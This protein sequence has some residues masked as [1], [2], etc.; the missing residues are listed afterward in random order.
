MLLTAAHVV[1]SLSAAHGIE[2]GEVRL[3]TGPATGSAD[4]RIGDVAFSS[5]PEPEYEIELDASLVRLDSHVSLDNHVRETVTTKRPRMLD[6]GEDYVRVF[7]R[8]IN[9]PGLTEGLD[10]FF[11][12]WRIPHTSPQSSSP[13]AR[14][15]GQ[16]TTSTSLQSRFTKPH[17]QTDSLPPSPPPDLLVSDE[18]LADSSVPSGTLGAFVL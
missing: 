14:C 18:S 15:T 6:G 8:G 4:P 11:P 10:V 16:S 5:P 7:K 9:P 3:M 12:L 17:S 13:T 1:G 2:T